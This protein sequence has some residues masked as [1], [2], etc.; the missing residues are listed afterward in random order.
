M[1]SD[2]QEI[3]N[4]I[5]EAGG[6][7]IGIDGGIIYFNDPMTKST[8]AVFEREFSLSAVRLKIEQ[9]REKFGYALLY[10]SSIHDAIAFITRAKRI[11]KNT[12]IDASVAATKIIMEYLKERTE[13][14]T[15]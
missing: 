7:F 15:G 4:T 11:P 5:D 13:S 9:S 12:V 2:W 3:E 1:T 6:H 14:T 8:L 10:Q